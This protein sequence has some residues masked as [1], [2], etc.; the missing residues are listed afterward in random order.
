MS[1]SKLIRCSD[2]GVP[3]LLDQLVPAPMP[4][5]PQAQYV[6]SRCDTARDVLLARVVW[7]RLIEPGD[8]VAG[9]LIDTLGALPALELLAGESGKYAREEGSAH[10]GT[11]GAARQ[12]RT[13]AAAAG[14]AIDGRTLSAAVARWL[15][16]L[17]R[18]A[19][20]TDLDRA[21]AAGLQVIG[22]ESI[23]WPTS[24]NDLGPHSPQ[25]L[26]ARGNPAELS[27]K[28]LA[29][30]GARACT[31]YGANIT[32]ELVDTA[33]SAGVAIVSGAAYGIDAVAHRAALA[34]GVPTIAVL[35]GGAD[36]AYPSAHESLLER[37]AET[38]VVCSEMVPGAAPTRWRFLQRNRAIAALAEA[39]LVTEAGMRS[40]S[41][42]TA[43]HAAE[44]GRNLGAVPGP[45]TSAA[46]A[47]CH[48]LIRDYGATLVSSSDELREF[49]GI[50]SAAEQL[51]PSA[52]DR[53]PAAHRRTLDAIP[54]RGFRSGDEIA[55]AAGLTGEETRAIL[56]ELEL[57]GWVARGDRADGSPP[58]WRLVRRE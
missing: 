52:S 2:S 20:L 25:L 32:A 1:I 18:S 58:R 41:L 34:A 14:I 56:A 19:S 37:I 35:A 7:S 26:W 5:Q 46:S 15:P 57:M 40:G 9:T 51:L 16:R 8:A 33:G 48:R 27:A 30:V 22:P 47:G 50:I 11:V 10:R 23:L 45:I 53:Q 31:G 44:L 39:T 49:M 24:L 6:E 4:V 17:D 28:A 21:V 13:A 42:N 38:G 36:R 12:L 54:L 55:L 43:G 29:V 3:E